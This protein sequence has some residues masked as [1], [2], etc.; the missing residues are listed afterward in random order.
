LAVSQLALTEYHW[1]WLFNLQC[2][3]VIEDKFGY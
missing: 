2:S 1:Y 3:M